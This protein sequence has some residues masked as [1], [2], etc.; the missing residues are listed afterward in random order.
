MYVHIHACVHT[1]PDPAPTDF[2]GTKHSPTHLKLK[3][4][5]CLITPAEPSYACAVTTE[6]ALRQ[7]K[8]KAL[9]KNETRCQCTGPDHTLM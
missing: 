2:S 7:H 1:G 8:I 3:C 6:R 5:A 9:L 4:S